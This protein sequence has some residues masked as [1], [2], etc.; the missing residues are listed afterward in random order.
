[1]HHECLCKKSNGWVFMQTRVS[2]IGV[3][4]STRAVCLCRL[5]KYLLIIGISKVDCHFRICIFF[6][7]R[8]FASRTGWTVEMLGL[9]VEPRCQNFKQW[10][11]FIS[12][13]VSKFQTGTQ[14]FWLNEFADALGEIPTTRMRNCLLSR[15][16]TQD[17]IYVW[18]DEHRDKIPVYLKPPRTHF[19]IY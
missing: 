5:G 16:V 10:R 4:I 19:T 1:M 2:L 6:W 15:P 3:R 8:N 13:M 18:H 17:L 14:N 7:C 9:K 11:L 12:Q